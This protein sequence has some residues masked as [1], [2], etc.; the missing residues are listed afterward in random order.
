MELTLKGLLDGV[1]EQENRCRELLLP[2]TE[3]QKRWSPSGHWSAIQCLDHVNLTLEGYLPGLRMAIRRGHE[4]GKRAAEPYAVS[5]LERW[6]LKSLEPPAR[7]RFRSPKMFRPAPE[8]RIEE[9]QQR[10]FLLREEL[11]QTVRSANGLDLAGIKLPSPAVSWF[12]ISL[13]T[14]FAAMISHDRRH[15]HQ[16]ERLTE[17]PDFPRDPAGAARPSQ[18][19]LE[20][21][22]DSVR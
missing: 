11:R 8:P 7:I 6:F 19:E 15:F 12:R 5:F 3:E 10:F 17:N 14:A 20:E 9:V 16:I 4:A 22:R 1:G 21:T 2:L 13:G 18:A